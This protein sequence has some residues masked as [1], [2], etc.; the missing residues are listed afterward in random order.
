MSI[1]VT[2]GAVAT[3]NNVALQIAAPRA[4]QAMTA[5]GQAS[6]IQ[7]SQGEIWTVVAEAAVFVEFGSNPDAASGKMR[8]R[9]LAGER[10]EFA[11]SANGER[12]AFVAG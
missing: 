9:M 1:Y 3:V 2:I 4:V 5:A 12:V 11:A 7:A 6:T 10:C 8:R